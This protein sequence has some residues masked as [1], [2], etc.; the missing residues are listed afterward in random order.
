MSGLF[1]NR[2]L[3]KHFVTFVLLTES[4]TFPERYKCIGKATEIMKK[5]NTQVAVHE[6]KIGQPQPSAYIA[7]KR[8]ELLEQK[9][10]AFDSLKRPIAATKHEVN[11][12]RGAW[13]AEI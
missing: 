3:M 6:E 7:M 11:S 4:Q 9:T 1:E 10:D 5:H 12:N 8:D 2:P 13:G